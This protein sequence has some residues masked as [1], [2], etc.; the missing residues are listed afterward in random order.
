[1]TTAVP[2]A[3]EAEAIFGVNLAGKEIQP[4]WLRVENHSEKIYYLV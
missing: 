2:S 4:I 3:K 1:V